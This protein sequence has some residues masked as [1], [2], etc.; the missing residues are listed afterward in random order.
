MRRRSARGLLWLPLVVGCAYYNAMWSAERSAKEAR[1][2]EARG[3]TAE[4]RTQ[5]SRAAVKAETVLARH[6]KSRWADDALVLRGEALTR[7]GNCAAA[8]RPL[9]DALKTTTTA[10]L[11][12]RAA[13]AA[14][15]CALA[16]G[17]PVRA[18]RLLASGGAWSDGRRRSRAA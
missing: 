17:D 16:A 11:T 2:L 3:R 18:D 1:R 7:T 12:E 13:L 6:P 5:W 8:A 4:A 10:A 9:D 14:A 15:E